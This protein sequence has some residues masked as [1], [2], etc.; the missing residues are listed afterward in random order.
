MNRSKLNIIEA[1]KPETGC[2]FIQMK[3]DARIRIH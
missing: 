1:Y 2:E 3:Y